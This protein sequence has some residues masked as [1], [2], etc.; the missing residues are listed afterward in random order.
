MG[1]LRI[2]TIAKPFP[3]TYQTEPE[4]KFSPGH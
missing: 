4:T 3:M 1:L 2:N